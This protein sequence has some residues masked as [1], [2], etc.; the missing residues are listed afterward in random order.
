MVE[1]VG[2]GC[3]VFT[4]SGFERK[5]FSTRHNHR[6]C[7]C[8]L[9]LDCQ[10]SAQ[11][12]ARISFCAAIGAIN[13]ERAQSA[14]LFVIDC[15][16]SDW[17]IIASIDLDVNVRGMDRV[18]STNQTIQFI[19]LHKLTI[20]HRAQPEMYLLVNA[21]CQQTPGKWFSVVRVAK[22]AA[23][24]TKQTKEIPTK[25]RKEKRILRFYPQHQ[26]HIDCLSIQ[27]KYAKSTTVL[28]A[29]DEAVN[30]LPMS[31]FVWRENLV[32]CALSKIFHIAT[33]QAINFGA[34]F[35]LL[36]Y[37]C[38]CWCASERLWNFPATTATAPTTKQ[39]L[40]TNEWRSKCKKRWNK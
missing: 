18:A 26:P 21:R 9:V 20:E 15:H 31:F 13:S 38:V 8:A 2:V 28:A 23:Q 1:R 33:R 19:D 25:C 27:M 16:K 7:H 3:S 10:L 32:K 35:S 4:P 34:I 6:W 17:R 11:I 24:N 22:M 39:W 5:V 37:V 40:F 36:V 12:E 30:W 29:F 14:G